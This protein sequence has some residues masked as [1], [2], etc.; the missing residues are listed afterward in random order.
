MKI[1]AALVRFSLGF[2]VSEAVRAGT[3]CQPSVLRGGVEGTAANR[4]I[5]NALGAS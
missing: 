3:A 1:H 5:T 4:A 2:E